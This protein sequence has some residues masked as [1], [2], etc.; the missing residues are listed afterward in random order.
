MSLILL[1]KSVMIGFENHAGL[2]EE[3]G[4][5]GEAAE[6]RARAEA[7]RQRRELPVL[8]LSP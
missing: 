1:A 6:L 3:L 5:G 2:L 7:V 8:P 4:R